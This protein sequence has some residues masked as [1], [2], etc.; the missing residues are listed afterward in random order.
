MLWFNIPNSFYNSMK[1]IINYLLNHFELSNQKREHKWPTNNPSSKETYIVDI[2]K[3]ILLDKGD[4]PLLRI[5]WTYENKERYLR[6]VIEFWFFKSLFFRF[7]IGDVH[8]H[9]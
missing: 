8:C 4:E 6:C 2:G 5:P 7:H 1:Y 9:K 3:Y